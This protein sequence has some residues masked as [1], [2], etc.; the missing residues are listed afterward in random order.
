M[1]TI[2]INLAKLKHVQMNAKGKSG[3][4]RGLFLPIELNHLYEGKDGNVYLDMIGFDLKEPRENQ[5]HLI[6]QSFPKEIRQ[7]MKDSPIL[8]NANINPER[9]DD[10]SNAVPNSVMDEGDDL[11]F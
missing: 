9:H 5:T 1:I 8:G 7:E 6:K 10:N 2:K 3:T 4:V 11:P